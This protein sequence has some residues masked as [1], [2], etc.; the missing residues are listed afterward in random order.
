MIG[1]GTGALSAVEEV[2]ALGPK[3]Y[4]TPERFAP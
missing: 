2:K 3:H 1:T 4:V